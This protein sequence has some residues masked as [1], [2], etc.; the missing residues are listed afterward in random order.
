MSGTS[1]D[2]VDVVAMRTDGAGEVAFLGHHYLVYSEELK[3]RLRSVCLGDVPLLDVLRM[4][5]D[6]SE[7]YAEAL[8]GA[9]A[10]LELDWAD[11][12]V[13]GVHG[14]TVRHKP[15]EGLTWQLG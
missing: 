7:L 10:A 6:V 15:D 11:V 2:G 14:Q 3:A 1:L 4:E 5:K 9:V 8:C 12:G 13:V